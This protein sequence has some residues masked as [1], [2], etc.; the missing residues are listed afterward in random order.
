MPSLHPQWRSKMIISNTTMRPTMLVAKTHH[1]YWHFLLASVARTSC[2]W[3]PCV[4]NC[5]RE[6]AASMS[7]SGLD[8]V[9]PRPADKPLALHAHQTLHVQK[10]LSQLVRGSREQCELFVVHLHGLQ[11]RRRRPRVPSGGAFAAEPLGGRRRRIGCE[12]RRHRVGVALGGPEVPPDLGLHLELE[13][14][15]G[16]EELMHQALVPGALA[17]ER[18]PSEI[19]LGCPRRCVV[20]LAGQLLQP[21]VRQRRSH[22]C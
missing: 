4:R 13:G 6:R 2:S 3:A 17:G 18:L 1:Q 9:E 5:V 10:G 15:L 14:L 20:D 11:R 7:S 19:R 16:L 21:P 12:G 8:F 22:A